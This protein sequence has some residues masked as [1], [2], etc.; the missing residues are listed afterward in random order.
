MVPEDAVLELD[1]R[2]VMVVVI[3][4]VASDCPANAMLGN[5]RCPANTE[6][7]A[8]RPLSLKHFSLILS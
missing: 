6:P 5:G 3:E 4:Q 2:L 1:Y 7:A 8:R